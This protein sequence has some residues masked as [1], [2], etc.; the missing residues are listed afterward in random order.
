MLNYLSRRTTTSPYVNFTVGEMIV[1]GEKRF[2]D[3]LKARPPDYVFLVDKDTFEFGYG[4]FGADPHYGQ[5]IVDWVNRQYTPTA[6]IGGEP[7]QGRD[8]GI[9]ILK[10]N[11]P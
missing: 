5:Q 1:F 4:P 10:R 6:L 11:N 7:L 3:N 9:K 2:F 8:F